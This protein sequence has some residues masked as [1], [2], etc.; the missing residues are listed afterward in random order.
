MSRRV[1]MLAVFLL[2]VWISVA[3]GSVA[4]AVVAVDDRGQAI[5]FANPPQRII[6]LAPNITELLFAVGA[7]SHVVAVSE[8]SD[9]PAD[10]MALPKI[11][12]ALGVDFEHILDLQ[13]DLVIA[14]LSGNGRRVIDRLEHLG[15]RVFVTEPRRFA[16]VERLLS[17][18]GQISGHPRKGS[19]Q[20]SRFG[21]QVAALRDRYARRAAISVFYLLSQR[22]LMTINGEHMISELLTLCGG[23][24]VFADYRLLAPTVNIED[25]MK[26]DADVILISS[27][28]PNV[29]QVRAQWLMMKDLKAAQTS[30]VFV[31]DA[32]LINRQAPRLVQG[33]EQ[34]CRLIDQARSG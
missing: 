21:K 13:P 26:R 17:V 7:G 15:I 1:I 6:S 28:V 27:T 4:L 16:D 5:E 10:A 25:I 3:M 8:Y 23:D 19:S 14:W 18:F 2:G 24:N 11:A 12:N 22:P 33:A 29:S 30:R 34:V 32:D 20:A 9:H 31:V